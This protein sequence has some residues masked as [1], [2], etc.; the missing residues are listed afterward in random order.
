MCQDACDHQFQN[1]LNI[2]N[3]ILQSL[4][5]VY[6]S[7]TLTTGK[8]IFYAITQLAEFYYSTNCNTVQIWS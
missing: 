5:C 8:D 6:T 2:M 3:R 7:Q 4:N 1:T